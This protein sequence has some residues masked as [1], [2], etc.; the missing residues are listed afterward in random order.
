MSRSPS[1]KALISKSAFI[2]YPT[3]F[4]IA[5]SSRSHSK[6]T[7]KVFVD[8]GIITTLKSVY[9]SIIPHN[10]AKFILSG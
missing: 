3:V 6:A 10:F 1:P 5:F 7:P 4:P 8:D 2:L 9:F